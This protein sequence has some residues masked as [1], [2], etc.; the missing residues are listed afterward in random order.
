MIKAQTMSRPERDLEPQDRDKPNPLLRLS[1]VWVSF[2]QP[3]RKRLQALRG[4]DLTLERGEALGLVGESGCGKSTLA[5]TILL[6]HRPDRGRILLEGEDLTALSTKEL[7]LRRRRFQM[8]FQDPRSSFN[9]RRTIGQSVAEPLEIF[10]LGKNREDRDRRVAE[11]LEQVGLDT[12]L[13]RRY[14]HELSGG[15]RQRAA[16]ARALATQPALLVA[17]EPTSALDVS[18]QAQV[19]NLLARFQ[20][21]RSLGL[22]FISH[23]LLL[24]RSLCDRTAVMYLGRIVELGSTPDIYENP[25]HPYTQALLQALPRLETSRPAATLPGD[26]PSPIDL[27][28]GCPFL[29]RCPRAGKDRRCAEQEPKLWEVTP[30][31]W[32]ACHL[33]DSRASDPGWYSKRKIRGDVSRNN[34]E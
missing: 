1:D 34:L 28:S 27:P 10:R 18:I 5:H 23:D 26:V 7:R 24:V 15:Q 14:P 11:L 33:A 30:G 22:L 6:L 17:D 3:G 19:V 12:D 20:A 31:H 4:L 29:P 25:L 13:A 2:P 8:I 16:V 32:A 21:E 9:P